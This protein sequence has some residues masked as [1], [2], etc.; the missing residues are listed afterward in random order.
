MGGC[1]KE[2]YGYQGTKVSGK[3]TS[4]APFP[5]ASASAART[6]ATVP[7]HVSRSG[8]ICT[9]ATRTDTFSAMPFLSA[10]GS[11]ATSERPGVQHERVVAP[12]QENEI[13]H[14]ERADRPDT[15]KQRRLA[16]AVQHLQ[17]ETAA[18]DLATLA[19]ELGQLVAEVLR[20]RKRFIAELGK[21]AL[22]AERHAGTVEQNC[23]L[24]PFALQ[25]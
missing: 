20:A 11:R 17:R 8:A 16:M 22:D 13:K 5:A 15:G 24:E 10:C 7:L 6:F 23:G 21:A 3:T 19:H 4:R 12:M 9:A 1:T 2:K 14:V 25:T 18:I